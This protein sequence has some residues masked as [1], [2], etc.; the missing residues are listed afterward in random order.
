MR[1][2]T[3]LTAA[4][5]MLPASGMAQANSGATAA[6]RPALE[7]MPGAFSTDTIFLT[8]DPG[9]GIKPLAEEMQQ[10]ALA[11]IADSLI[12]PTPLPMPPIIGKTWTFQGS[13]PGGSQGFMGEAFV[14]FS[15]KGEVKRVGLSQSTLNSRL[16]DALVAAVKSGVNNGAFMAYQNATRG[17]GG[18]VFI[19]LRT[20]PLPQFREK[21]AEYVRQPLAGV[22]LPQAEAPKKGGIATFPVRELQ[23]PIVRLTSTA[24]V[25]GSGPKPV[26]PMQE[27]EVRQDGFVHVEFVIGGDGRVLPGTFRLANAMT[28]GYARAVQHAI[29]SFTF[30][31]AMVDGCGVASRLTYSFTFDVD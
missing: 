8:L 27:R 21:A 15:G 29:E 4:L 11:V 16:D 23:V 10:T 3:L 18:F 24:A 31:P 26:F 5:L 13:G 19:G 22:A 6:C 28:A 2:T 25:P 14:E 7:P 12:L 20:I 30:T 1:R 17:P 9:Y